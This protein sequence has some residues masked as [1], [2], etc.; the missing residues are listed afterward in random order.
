MISSTPLPTPRSKHFCYSLPAVAHAVANALLAR[1]VVHGPWWL[2]CGRDA[3]AIAQT[4][5]RV[6]PCAS[7]SHASRFSKRLAP[8]QAIVIVI[9]LPSVW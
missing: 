4:G 8:C 5:A 7:C 6:A 1:H 9:S 2:R 3:D